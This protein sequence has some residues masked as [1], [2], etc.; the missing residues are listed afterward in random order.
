MN[1]EFKTALNNFLKTPNIDIE[2]IVKGCVN[3]F[4]KNGYCQYKENIGWV[5]NNLFDMFIRMYA[6]C[7]CSNIEIDIRKFDYDGNFKESKKI[8]LY[9]IVNDVWDS[10][11]GTEEYT[12]K[13]L[14]DMPVEQ[15]ER[16]ARETIINDV[17]DIICFA[18]D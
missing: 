4:Y 7:M 13:E 18:G 1:T 11:M 16:I 12:E 10:I 15:Y 3:K 5:N 14:M 6:N 9:D 17:T 8:C 2:K